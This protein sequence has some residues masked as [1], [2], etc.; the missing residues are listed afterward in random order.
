[1]KV[2]YSNV[3]NPKNF[4]QIRTGICEADLHLSDEEKELVKCEVNYLLNTKTKEELNMIVLKWISE[5][6]ENKQFS[7]G[8]IYKI[9]LLDNA[10]F[11]SNLEILKKQIGEASRKNEQV[12]TRSMKLASNSALR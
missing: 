3:R 9:Y 5:R 1:M 10:I 8:E 11:M 6:N 7:D 2:Y 4:V 12:L